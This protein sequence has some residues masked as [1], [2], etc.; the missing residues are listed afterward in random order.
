M[1][2][3]FFSITY[4]DFFPTVKFICTKHSAIYIYIYSGE[5]EL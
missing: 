4:L 3:D 1:L 2:E 5:C